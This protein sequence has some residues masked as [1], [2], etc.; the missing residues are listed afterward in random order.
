MATTA[1]PRLLRSA[2]WA[3]F[4]HF[5]Q[6]WLPAREIDWNS[7]SL[8][9]PEDEIESIPEVCFANA[10]R[11]REMGAVA[12]D[13]WERYCSLERAFGWVGRRLCELSRARREYVQGGQALEFMRDLRFRRCRVKYFR[14]RV[15][16]ALRAP[17]VQ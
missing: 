6:D 13:Q 16:K 10:G 12:R 9:V 4:W 17:D 15:G 5:P 2:L 3:I 7:F 14:W 11:A 8:H 1:I